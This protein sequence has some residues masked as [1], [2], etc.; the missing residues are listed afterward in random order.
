MRALAIQTET[1]YE[2]QVKR[3]AM[4]DAA[5]FDSQNT[6]I[7]SARPNSL[8]VTRKGVTVTLVRPPW[9]TEWGAPRYAD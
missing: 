6:R 5:L 1:E 2:W 3:A 7:L 4:I 8:T 9:R